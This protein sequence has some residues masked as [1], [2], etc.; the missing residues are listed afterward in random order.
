MSF[1]SDC[2]DLIGSCANKL[3]IVQSSQSVEEVKP[4]QLIDPTTGETCDL[5]KYFQ[6]APWGPSSSSSSSSPGPTGK[7]GVEIVTKGWYTDPVYKSR[8]AELHDEAE[9]KLGVVRWHIDQTMTLY[10]GIYLAQAT[11]WVNDVTVKVYPFYFE[12]KPNLQAVMPSGPLQVWELRMAIRDTCPDNNFLLDSVEFSTEEIMWAIRRPI[13]Y[14]NEANPPLDP[15]P[16][17]GFPFRYNWLDAAVGEL[18]LMAAIWM[19]RNDLDYSAAGLQIMDTKKWP[20]Y[21]KLGMEKKT[22]WQE[23]TKQKKMAINASQ[24]YGTITGYRAN[25]Y[26]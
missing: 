2:L 10:A 9:L 13:E 6:P 18:L 19:R 12:V 3:W 16:I 21:Q 26:R 24:A 20:D 15:M 17:D 1:S 22:A 5:S 11:V 4:V 23:F 8:F 7:N 14:W 25:P